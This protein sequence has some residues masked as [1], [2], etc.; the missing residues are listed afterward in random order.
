MFMN[1]SPFNLVDLQRL[2]KLSALGA[3][4]YVIAAAFAAALE[5]DDS[6]FKHWS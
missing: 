5:A 6:L 2:K 4:E 3:D 1:L